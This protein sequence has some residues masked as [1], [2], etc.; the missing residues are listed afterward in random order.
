VDY[1][2]QRMVMYPHLNAAGILFGGVTLSWIVEDAIIF[3]T[4]M[5]ETN[6]IAAV[7]MSEVSFQSV[8]NI[9]DILI[10]EVELV[11]T[12]T[13]SI[14]VKCMLKNKTTKK[15]IVQVDEVIIVTLDFNKQPT[16]HKFAK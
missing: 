1:G 13:T 16:K 10:S 12:G 2:T 7:K 6:K 8:A 14:T 5:L 9:G 15:V 11:R 3:A 4:N